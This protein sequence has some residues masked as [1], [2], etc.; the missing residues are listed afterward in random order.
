MPNLVGTGLNQV[1][2]N[3][4]LGGLAYQD[5]EH[6]SIKDLDLKNLSQINSEISD[7][8]SDVFVYDTHKDSDGGAWRK[9]TQ[10]TSWYNETLGTATRGTRK[11]FPAVAVIVAETTKVTI[12]DGDDPDLPMW[13]VFN[14]SAS[15][16]WTPNNTN[17]LGVSYFTFTSISMLNGI[18]AMGAD[19]D[20]D[21]TN[22]VLIKVSFIEDT[23]YFHGVNSVSSSY[24]AGGFGRYRGSIA[25][26]DSGNGHININDT[27]KIANV[28]V[29]D[30]AMTVLPNAPI[31]DTTGLPVPTIAVA[32]GKAGSANGGVSVIKDD[33][34]VVDIIATTGAG[35]YA[36]YNVEFGS[37][38]ELI[39]TQAYDDY[40]ASVNIFDD[41][42]SSDISANN[43]YTE[44]RSYYYNNG[45]PD[46]RGASGIARPTLKYVSNSSGGDIAFGLQ[47]TDAKLTLL[48]EPEG[49]G[50]NNQYS[51]VAY[52]GSDYNTGYMVG[53]N[54][55]AFLS[56]TD[57]TNAIEYVQNGYFNNDVSSWTIGTT[58]TTAT[59]NANRLLITAPSSGPSW[60]YVYQGITTEIGKTYKI[61][62]HYD[63]GNVDGR[64]NVR[65]DSSNTVSGALFYA[66]LGTGADAKTYY[67]TFTATATTTYILLY[68]KS[69]SGG[70]SAYDEVSVTLEK[71]R[72]VN[73][74]GL[75]VYGT[76]TKQ[77]VATG[78]EL[79][80]Y[81]GWSS[82]NYLR[83]PYNSDLDFGTGN[84]SYMFWYNPNDA[85]SGDVLFTRWSRNI[86]NSTA[87]RIGVYFNSG[88]L[89][90]DLTDDG[91]SGYQGHFGS[92]GTQDS[93]EW[94]CAVILR[95]G[96]NL[97]IWIDGVNYRN[98]ALNSSADGSYT[99]TS[100]VLEIG[101]SP[102]MGAAEAGL[103]LA[104]FRV[105]GTAPSPEQIKKMYNDEKHLFQENAKAT[106]YGSSDAVTGLAHDDSTD[107]LHVGT[108][109]GRSE[110]QG[111]CRINNTTTA[112]TTAISASNGLVAEQ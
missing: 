9:R 99:N 94:H 85:E 7:T 53:D 63:R 110:F 40:Y 95:R 102:N 39:H 13:M 77:P 4:M 58:G 51:A 15:S 45:I 24:P 62:L 28:H 23:G 109:A 78:A 49:A 106:L 31:D 64:I 84:W 71:D 14:R 89:R 65:N 56:D 26:R 100:A 55:G 27:D 59:L 91:A 41:I 57:T 34:S 22:G 87:G 48:S 73:N 42:P 47:D 21:N 111:L 104:L 108:S 17:I 105:S 98:A 54:K 52:I 8:A 69:T 76:V 72:S 25:E 18:F 5:P 10:H 38:N 74:N 2:T 46:I 82:S 1:P 43:V 12:Y 67:N 92:D 90:V 3:G 44:A 50:T 11:E 70:T 107:S 35:G 86:N 103:E 36:S 83:Q 96:S 20:S 30:V 32:V 101:N 37:N 88:N 16:G 93:N 97:E 68:A 6:A 60:G 19:Y 61:S 81:S 66:D 29:N 33:G 80:S 79:V 75:Q 112:V